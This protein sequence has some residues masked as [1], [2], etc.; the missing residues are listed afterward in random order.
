[1]CIR[2]RCGD[3]ARLVRGAPGLVVKEDGEP[4]TWVISVHFKAS[5]KDNSKENVAINPDLADDCEVNKAQFHELIEWVQENPEPRI[6]VAGDFNR[7]L[8]KNGDNRYSDLE[9]AGR[10]FEIYPKIDSVCFKSEYLVDMRNS[11]R[12]FDKENNGVDD[13]TRI[14][15]FTPGSNKGIDHFLVCLLYT[16]PSPRDS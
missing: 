1:M 3:E 13:D 9:A 11:W 10:S 6:V 12:E 4:E 15:V 5:C 16:S 7:K 8:L 2:D 14:Q